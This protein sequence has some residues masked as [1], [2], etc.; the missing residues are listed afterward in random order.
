MTLQD[1]IHLARMT[2]LNDPEGTTWPDAAIIEALNDA[3]RIL[4]LMRPDCTAT[5]LI[6]STTAGT[7]QAIPVNGE[8]LLRVVCN[9]NADDSIGRAIKMVDQD[10]LNAMSP[11][12]RQQYGQKVYEYCFDVRHPKT[13]HIYPA[14][15]DGKKIEIE[16]SK[17]PPTFTPS[18]LIQALPFADIYSQPLQELLM[19]KLL[20]GDASS[21]IP[22][23]SY[24]SNAATML[25]A[26][27][28][29]DVMVLPENKGVQA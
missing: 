15:G 4:V 16:Y 8:R 18:D 12:W 21:G 14:V 24:F 20:T 13:F 7:R 9:V 11:D 19:Y 27:M 10:D 2:Q 1:F 22:S 25:G 26:K 5:T 29:A 3:M 28:A 23:G 6:V 17:S